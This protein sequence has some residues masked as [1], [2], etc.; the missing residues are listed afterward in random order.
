MLH[1]DKTPHLQLP[2]PHQYNTLEVD[3]LRIRAALQQ[4]DGHLSGIDA[5]LAIESE[6]DLDTLHEIVEAVKLAHQDIAALQALV[7]TEIAAA[8]ATVEEDISAL[9]GE[10]SATQG[11]LSALRPLIYAGL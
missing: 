3:V 4:L 10:L 9:Q 5:L 11:E 7:D 1:D 8:I 6:E 2:L